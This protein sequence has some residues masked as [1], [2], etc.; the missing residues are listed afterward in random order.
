MFVRALVLGFVLAE[1]S[2]VAYIGGVGIST[3]VDQVNPGLCLVIVAIVLA[4]LAWYAVSRGVVRNVEQ[5]MRSQRVDLLLSALLGIWA[6]NVLSSFT[7][8]FHKEVEK[9]D[10]LLALL[11]AAFLLIIIVSSLTRSLLARRKRD[12]YQLYFLTDEEIQHDT[13][14]VLA[15]QEQ[16]TQFAQTVL[17]S[18]SESGL[19]YGLDGPWGTGKTSFINLA[20]NYWRQKAAREVIVF[21]FE[22][23]RYALDPDLA[24]RFIRDL[25]AEIQH[26]IFIPEFRPVATRYSR[27]L[28]GKADFS[29]LGFKLALESSGETID[30]LLED[31][32]EVLRRIRRRLIVVVDDLD[33]LEPKAINNVLFTVRRTFKLSQAAYI[34]CYDTENLL[35][36]KEEGERARQ[37]LEKFINIK[38]SLFVDSSAL[39]RFLE[40][41]WNKDE[42]KYQAIPSETMLKLASILS[43]L[44]QILKGDQAPSYMPLIG[45]MRKLK[46]FVNAV[47]LMQIEKTDLARTDFDRRDLINLMLLHWNY[48]GIFRRIYLEE[49]EGRSGIFSIK[50]K[51]DSGSP[52]Y[53]NAEGYADF[54]KLCTGPDKFL[55]EQLFGS[56]SV[57]LGEYGLVDESV[58][59]SRACFNSGQHRNLEKFLKLIVR[60][61]TPEP[62]TTFRLYQEAVSKVIE[63]AAVETVLSESEFTLDRGED[64]HDQFWR[65]LVSQSYKFNSIAAEDSINTLVEYL[66]K[67]S[68][69]DTGERALRHRSSYNLIRL[70]DRAGWG[71]TSGK[72]RQNNT[73]ENVIEIAHRIYGEEKHTGRGLIDRLAEEVRGVLGLYDLMLF[74]LQCSADRLGQIYNLHTALIVHEDMNAPTSGP[75]NALAIAGMRT[76]SQRVFALFKSR[77]IDTRRNLFD[78]IDAISDVEFLGAASNNTSM[79]GLDVRLRDLIEGAR[80]LTKTF[81]VYQL[82]N[83]QAGKGSGVGCGY[84]DPAGTADKGEIAVLMNDYLFDVCFNPEIKEQNAEHF[85]DFCLCNLTSGFESGSDEDGYHPTPQGLANELNSSTLAHYW[86]KNGKAIKARNLTSY[87]KRVVTLRYAVTYKD[88]LPG[89]FDVLDRIQSESKAEV[90]DKSEIEGLANNP[91]SG[92]VIG[93]A[94]ATENCSRE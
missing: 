69:V 14:D 56:N 83:R 39:C 70:L 90:Q 78:D 77:Y 10:P 49:T 68:S 61:A 87:D 28:K 79:D 18:G 1:I 21:R 29:F 20:N 2:R 50:T 54:V 9:A 73:S 31:I 86:A 24:E 11:V 55:L 63:G 45:D 65:I 80:S 12:S 46:R 38:L 91:C 52:E 15:N 76:L 74:R 42:D 34:L 26:Q 27:M 40:R 58:R 53:V 48:P 23:L 84:Y 19:V 92:S 88:G 60:F 30:E 43:E 44:T 25:S 6:N 64:A 35:A 4:L 62:R 22:P 72:Q 85:L 8:K 16:A 82:A 67:Y 75:V 89:A 66:P 81:I 47:L 71:R 13:D 33:R 93:T 57:R 36:T 32:D 51:T 41:D 3:L 59:E 37:F 17:E 7:Q 5:L 94:T